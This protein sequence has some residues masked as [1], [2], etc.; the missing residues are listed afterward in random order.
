MIFPCPCNENTGP[1]EYHKV[2][3]RMRLLEKECLTQSRLLDEA[4][5]VLELAIKELEF[6]ARHGE[7]DAVKALNISNEF[8]AKLKAHREGK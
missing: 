3:I 7:A 2:E 6:D 5:K 4:E 8:L 1:C